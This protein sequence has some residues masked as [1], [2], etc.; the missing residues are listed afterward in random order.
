[1]SRIKLVHPKI[2][3]Q[4]MVNTFVED[5]L[6]YN[7]SF[8]GFDRLEKFSDY[9]E[10]LAYMESQKDEKQLEE[11]RVPAEVRFVTDEKEAYIIGIVNI[12]YRLNEYLNDFGGHIGISIARNFRNKGFGTKALKLALQRCKELNID[13]VLITCNKTNQPS[14]KMIT[15]NGGVLENEITE[16]NGNVVQRYWVEN[17]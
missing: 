13:K 16:E 12:R 7:S 15:N 3:H 11:G 9:Q 2:E 1:M 5:T 10:W 17:K 14:A 4:A 8:H 6:K